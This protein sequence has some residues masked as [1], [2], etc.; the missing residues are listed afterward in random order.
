MVRL[1][2]TIKRYIGT[3]TD[4][5]PTDDVPA[6]SSFL[7]TTTGTV[8]RFDGRMWIAAP[9]GEEVSGLLEVVISLLIDV[10]EALYNL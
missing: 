3:S 9:G 5:K 8:F 10:R 7:E 6:G 2:G 4:E 1:E